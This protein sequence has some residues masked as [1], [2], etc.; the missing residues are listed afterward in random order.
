[1]ASVL[2]SSPTPLVQADPLNQPGPKPAGQVK[3]STLLTKLGQADQVDIPKSEVRAIA[4]ASGFNPRHELNGLLKVLEDKRLIE[5]SENEV[6]VLGITTRGSLGH[7]ADIFQDAEPTQ[8]ENASLTLAELASTAPVRSSD[9]VE[10]IG[11]EH[12]L[13]KAQ[14]IDFLRRAEEVGFVDKEGEGDDKILFNGN[15]FRRDSV[16]KSRMVLASLTESDQKLVTEI[17]GQLSIVGCL[18]VK[19]VERVLTKPLFEKLIAAGVYDLNQVTNEKGN[20]VYVTAPSAFHK[21]VDPMIDDCFDMAKSLVAALTYGMKSRSASQG[22]ISMLPALLGKLISGREIGPATAIGQDYR[23]LE[24]NRVIKLRAD[25]SYPDR[26]YMRLVKTE[27][28]Q[29]ALQVLTQGNAYEES[30]TSL[31][32]APMSGYIGPEETRSSVRRRQSAMSKKTTQDVLEA[33]RGGRTL[34]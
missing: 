22:R 6:S 30:L 5:Q 2:A 28:G 27:I 16:V 1:M 9:I 12:E 15:L 3:A 19:H 26:Y 34:R 32:S 10:Q 25:I 7:A 29:L 17:S 13:T 31:V 24:V 21:F 23:V 11:D 18:T 4:V 20:H 8:Y 14:T 33:V